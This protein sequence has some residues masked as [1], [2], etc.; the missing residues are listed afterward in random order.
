ML[1]KLI[2]IITNLQLMILDLEKD[3]DIYNS[4]FLEGQVNEL[5]IIRDDLKKK[6]GEIMS[7]GVDKSMDTV[8]YVIKTLIDVLYAKGVLDIIEYN[9]FNDAKTHEDLDS[10]IDAMYDAIGSVSRE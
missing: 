7:L 6:E 10:I 2:H 3:G 4:K 1:K 5:K 8:K 9:L